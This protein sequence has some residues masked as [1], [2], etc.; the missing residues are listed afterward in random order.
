M[1]LKN[2][3]NAS[4]LPSDCSKRVVKFLEVDDWLKFGV[5]KNEWKNFVFWWFSGFFVKIYILITSYFYSE[6]NL[7][8]F[9]TKFL[10]FTTKFILQ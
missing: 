2:V 4:K 9:N 6:K 1:S 8:D 3:P 5:V 10:R 7:F